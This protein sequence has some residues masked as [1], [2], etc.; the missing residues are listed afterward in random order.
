MSKIFK[1]GQ[2]TIPN[3]NS[4]GESAEF[5]KFSGGGRRRGKGVTVRFGDVIICLI[6]PALTKVYKQVAYW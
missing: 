2:K 1:D 3:N 5:S 4:M 6:I